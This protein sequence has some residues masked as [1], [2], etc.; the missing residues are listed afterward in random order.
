MA[1]WGVEYLMLFRPDLT[2]VADWG[3]EYL[4]LCR[5]D[6][7]FVAHWGVEYVTHSDCFYLQIG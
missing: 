4:M 2:F 7:T 6:L 5:P 1:D 3:V